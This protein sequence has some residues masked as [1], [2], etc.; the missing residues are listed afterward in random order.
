MIVT[1]PKGVAK[2]SGMKLSDNIQILTDG[3]KIVI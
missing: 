3:E 2:K 1:I